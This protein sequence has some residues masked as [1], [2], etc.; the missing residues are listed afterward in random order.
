[1]NS[2]EMPESTL[3]RSHWRSVAV[4]HWKLS[5]L[6]QVRAGV[7]LSRKQEISLQDAVG[8]RLVDKKL[9]GK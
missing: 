7:Q 5:E 3:E 8:S 1:M 2:L 6:F 4:T 9:I